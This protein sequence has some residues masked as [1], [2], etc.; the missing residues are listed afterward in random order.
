M[1][2]ILGATEVN[3]CIDDIAVWSTMLVYILYLY[4]R[5]LICFPTYDKLADLVK[6]QVFESSH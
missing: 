4:T 2:L 3:L 5:K 6:Q 1:Y